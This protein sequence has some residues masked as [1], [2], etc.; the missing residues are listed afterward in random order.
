MKVCY[1]EMKVSLEVA[2]IIDNSEP[3]KLKLKFKKWTLT[4]DRRTIR[5]VF[6]TIEPKLT[7]K[8]NEKLHTL[9]V[10]GEVDV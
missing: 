2:N 3:V 6:K 1:S 7:K 4:A 8:F 5:K 9:L 10:T